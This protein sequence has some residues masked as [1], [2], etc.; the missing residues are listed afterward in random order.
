VVTLVAAGGGGEDGVVALVA[1]GGGGKDGG[2][3]EVSKNE[4]QETCY[5]NWQ[6][7]YNVTINP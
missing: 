3:L 6:A 5:H 1:A 7:Q 2:R 4:T